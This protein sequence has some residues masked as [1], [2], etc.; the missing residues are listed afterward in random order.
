M[1]LTQ[2]LDKK[3][4]DLLKSG[5]SFNAG[6]KGGEE[7]A[8]SAGD[9]YDRLV[10][11]FNTISEPKAVG[12]VVESVKPAKAEPEPKPI[13]KKPKPKPSASK[14]DLTP[15]LLQAVLSLMLPEAP[16]PKPSSPPSPSPPPEPPT[17]SLPTPLPLLDCKFDDKFSLRKKP[18]QLSDNKKLKKAVKREMKSAQREIR[19]DNQF[20]ARQ[21][22]KEQL[23]K[24]AE[25]KEKVKKIYSSLYNQQ[26]EGNVLAKEK[27]KSKKKFKL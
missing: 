24:D 22:L 26:H 15:E 27:R 20:L 12:K 19:R 13:A 10:G 21:Q 18:T 23:E 6:G 11:T 8:E 5:V 2:E 9:E 7:V 1:D 4:K 14:N 3:W 25:R 16:E 17:I